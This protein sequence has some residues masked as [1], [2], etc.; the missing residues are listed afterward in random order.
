[1][2]QV[3]HV[4]VSCLAV[5]MLRAPGSAAAGFP[6]RLGPRRHHRGAIPTDL[7]GLLHLLEM[8]L[9]RL[10]IWFESNLPCIPFFY[11]SCIRFGP[12]EVGPLRWVPLLHHLGIL[13]MD[14]GNGALSDFAYCGLDVPICV[15]EEHVC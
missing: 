13:K 14:P 4:K 1:M 11:G 6:T 10:A 12:Q 2:V 5:Q 7:G 8:F 9:G 3:E 15:I